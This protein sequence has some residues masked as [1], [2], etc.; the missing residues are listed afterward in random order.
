MAEFSSN[1]LRIHYQHLGS[2]GTPVLF[3]HGLV[4]DN[5]S[6]WYFTAGHR[7]GCNQEA[8][9]MDLRGHGKSER[10]ASGY[11][12]E[13][14][15]EDVVSLLNHLQIQQ[16]VHVVGNSFGGLL[17]LSLAVHHPAR[18]ASVFLVDAHMGA[19]GWGEEMTKTLRKEGEERDALIAEHFKSWL[20]RHRG[21][22]RNRLAQ[23]ASSLVY[24]TSLLDDL[25]ASEDITK[26][27]LQSLSMPIRG[28]YGSQSDLAADVQVLA[29]S[30][31]D[32]EVAWFEGAT[33]SVLWEATED[34]VKGIQHWV[35]D[36]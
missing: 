13:D 32:F 5:L 25:E 1:G 6:S 26:D 11:R 35:G 4:M 21:R 10:P 27:Q 9:L 3:L 19:Q 17:A 36:A 8:I 29:E 22:K 18:V 2:G 12:V 30:I 23:V 34:V 31:P 14:L 24:G 28:I 20:G 16:P 15:L 33:H 7:V